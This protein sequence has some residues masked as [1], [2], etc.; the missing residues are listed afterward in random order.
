VYLIQEDPALQITPL[1]LN[2]DNQGSW[3]VSLGDDGGVLAVVALAPHASAKASYW[4]SIVPY[5]GR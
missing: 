3:N 5:L 4:L 2:S 1:A